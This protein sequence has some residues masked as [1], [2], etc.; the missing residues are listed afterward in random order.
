MKCLESGIWCAYKTVIFNIGDVKS[1]EVRSELST[2]AKVLLDKSE[3][4]AARLLAALDS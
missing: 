4:S 2:K 1:E 3:A